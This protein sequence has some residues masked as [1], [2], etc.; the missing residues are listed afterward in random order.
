MGWRRQREQSQQSAA[1]ARTPREW[2]ET[3]TEMGFLNMDAKF[4]LSEIAI[5]LPLISLLLKTDCRALCFP[6]GWEGSRSLFGV[7]QQTSV[8]RPVAFPLHRNGKPVSREQET[9]HDTDKINY[10]LCISVTQAKLLM[11]LTT[12][13]PIAPTEAAMAKKNVSLAPSTALSSVSSRRPR[14]GIAAN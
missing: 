2:G 1:G 5:L 11:V 8:D 9:K 14:R 13:R 4:K 6:E 10:Q 3:C 7:Q 12:R